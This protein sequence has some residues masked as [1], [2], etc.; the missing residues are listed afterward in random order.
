MPRREVTAAAAACPLCGAGA[1]AAVLAEAG[2]SA[3]ETI[4]RLAQRNP[5]WRRENGACPAC[6]QQ[7]LLE[8][9]LEQGE[10]ALHAAVQAA[11]PLDAEA[12]FGALP[13][14]LRLHAHPRYAGAGVT[15]AM[16]DAAFYPHPDLIRPRNRIRAW[17]DAAREPVRSVTLAPDDEA[18]WPEW[19]ASDAGQ[20][21][22]LMTSTVAAGS[23]TLS[24]GLYRG[25]ASEADVVLVQVRD[26]AGRITNA[27][28][29]RALDWLRW[30]GPALGV[31]VVNLS[32][33]GDPVAVGA[34][35][36]VDEAVAALVAEGITV[37]AAAGNDGVRRLVPPG[38]APEAL[39]IGGIDDKSTFDHSEREIWRSNF[40]ETSGGAG[41]PE[42][43]A[44]SLWVVAP[45][46][47]GTDLEAEAARLFER[48]AAGDSSAD[49]RLG[50]LKMVTPHYQH[51]EGTSFA[52]P[53]VA[54]VVACMLEANPALTPGG[55]RAA[56]IGAAQLVP[57]APAE[58]Q[59]SGVLDAG[60]AV[61]LGLAENHGTNI[62]GAA[63]PRLTEASIEF[64]FH[65]HK[66][67][68][69]S[70]VGSWDGWSRPGVVAE[71]VEPGLWQASMPSRR[72]R[73]LYKFLVDDRVW[74]A[75]PANP[76]RAHDGLG[77]WNSVL[78]IER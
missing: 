12:V 24:H 55:V 25:L 59:G 44:P 47:P 76:A 70:I 32:L 56:L 54:G 63:F 6:L 46:L 57:G 58:R 35:N 13:T 3:P 1:T 27:S 61:A 23:G 75:D 37:V 2:W 74:L 9:L 15:V 69:V 77:G 53:I 21:H 73:H 4:A 68:S 36:P 31:R 39:T 34:P 16:V 45:I 26:T 29:A 8:R 51:V 7:E 20:W 30:H 33:G 60:R 66:A 62:T 65:D 48:R 10:E 72:G 78:A 17:A 50:E 18:Q 52:A 38:S 22:G 19:D 41:K 71:R 42:L 11:W 28:V 40:G 5:G 14:P 49:V 64:V 43:V 67:G